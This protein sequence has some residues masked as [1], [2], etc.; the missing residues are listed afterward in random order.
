MRPIISIKGLT[1]TYGD[2][3]RGVKPTSLEIPSRRDLRPLGAE[4]RRQDHA[5]Q[6][7][8]RHR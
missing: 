8:L 5:D 2:G 6:H 1:K 7:R 3:F 4:R